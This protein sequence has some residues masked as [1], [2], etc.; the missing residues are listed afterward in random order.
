MTTTEPHQ[1]NAAALTDEGPQ[2]ITSRS[3]TA[4]GE[5]LRELGAVLRLSEAEAA[6]LEA[7]AAPEDETMVLN[8]GPQHPS[9]HGVLRLMLE[10]KGETVVRTKPIVGYL[11]TGMEWQGEELTYL[12]GPT[13]VTRMDYASPLFTELAFALSVEK[14]LGITDDMPA[15]A[16]WI[17]M[18]MVELNRIASHLLFLA[19]NGMDIGA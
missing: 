11:H 7:D 14:L 2:E 9:T 16:T 17:R 4:A 19:T 12:Q 18:L 3:V 1:S 8:M 5:R 13:N 15:R 6:Q 10:L